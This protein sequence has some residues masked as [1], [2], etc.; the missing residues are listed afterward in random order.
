MAG[1]ALDAF[2]RQVEGFCRARGWREWQYL[3]G[4]R[5]GRSLVTLYEEDFPDFT[6]TDLFL[7]L[8]AADTDDPRRLRSL[9]ALLASAYFEGRT[10][11][12]ASKSAG[13]QVRSEVEFEGQLIPWREVPGQWARIA[14]VSR[15]HALADAWRGALRGELS[16]TLERWHEALRAQLATLGETDWLGFWAELGG[17]DL[18]ALARM[19]TS[20]LEQSSEVFGHALGIYLA[21]LELPIDDVWSADVDWA[22]RAARFDVVFPTIGRT[23]L[24]VRASR[25]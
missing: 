4:L 2:E 5:L 3:A 6:S 17:L 1:F 19:S 12:L 10:R 16:P 7:D 15:R 22:M 25:D 24:L 20:I 18:A 14:E 8:R 11:E 13:F 9:S 21:Q 23:P